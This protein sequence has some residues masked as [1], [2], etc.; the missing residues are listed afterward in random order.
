M[1]E[2]KGSAG[3]SVHFASRIPLVLGAPCSAVYRHCR[4]CSF[5]W[6]DRCG[7]SRGEGEGQNHEPDCVLPLTTTSAAAVSAAV[8]SLV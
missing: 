4:L 3:K 1:Q 2:E 6:V 8:L 7:S 5:V